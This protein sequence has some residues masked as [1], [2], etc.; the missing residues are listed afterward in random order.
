MTQSRWIVNSYQQ[1]SN[2]RINS[3][4]N[5]VAEVVGFLVVS[6]PSDLC[7]CVCESVCVCVCVCMYDPSLI[8]FRLAFS[9]IFLFLLI[10]LLFFQFL[11]AHTNACPFLFLFVHFPFSQSRFVDF[12]LDNAGDGMVGDDFEKNKK[13]CK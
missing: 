1:C 3:G 5:S 9:L 12:D 8:D 6:L 13:L 2:K 7:V 11:F 10:S 4:V